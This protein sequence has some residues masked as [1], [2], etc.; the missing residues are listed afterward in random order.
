MADK[1]ITQLSGATAFTGTELFAVVQNNQTKKAT[2]NDIIGGGIR[3]GLGWAR[4]DD[5]VYTSGSTFVVSGNTQSTLPNNGNVVYTSYTFNNF[6]FYD[7]STQK[8]QVENEG[9]VYVMTI[10]FKA[11][12]ANTNQT[13][14]KVSLSSTTGTTYDRVGFEI[15][16]PKGNDATHNVHQVIQFY[17]DSD[18]V[19]NGNQLLVEAIGND[20]E[21]WDIIYFIQRTQNWKIT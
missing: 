10:V 14:L 9:D 15:N 8:V 5:G 18:F 4:Y 12:T 20:V 6:Q 11:K 17:S 2:Y 1:R 13:Y 21:I 7:S 16:F 19:S 3:G